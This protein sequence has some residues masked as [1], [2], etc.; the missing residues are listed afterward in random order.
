MPSRA[1]TLV[2]A[3]V[4]AC[5]IIG[6]YLVFSPEVKIKY[7]STWISLIIC[8]AVTSV[9]SLLLRIV[10][11]R[12]NKR[13]D[14]LFGSGESKEAINVVEQRQEEMDMT[15]KENTAFRYSL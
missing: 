11:A 4:S 9:L 2:L 5:S 3:H 12:E 7:R 13:R 8:M 6:P 10:L 14:S 1:L 15:D